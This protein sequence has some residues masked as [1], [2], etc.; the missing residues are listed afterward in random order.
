MKKYELNSRVR[1]I[2]K[3]FRCSQNHAYNVKRIF[4]GTDGL[5]YHDLQAVVK[6]EIPTNNEDIPDYHSEYLHSITFKEL[7]KA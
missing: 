6:P 4:L 7:E 2:G 1:Y 5:Y 3:D